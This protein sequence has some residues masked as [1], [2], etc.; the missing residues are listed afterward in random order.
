M[1]QQPVK[2]VFFDLGETLLTFGR[3]RLGRLFRRSAR[4][5]YDYL[6]Q[7]G[8]PVGP[9]GLYALRNLAAIRFCHIGATLTGRDFDALQL[10]KRVN[11][12]I[13]VEL[14]D[15]QWD[16]LIWK[17]YQPLAQKAWIEPDIAA[18]L[19]R[20]RQMHLKL[21]ILSNTFINRCCLERHLEQIGIRRYF[22]VCLFSYEFPK[23]KPHPSIF[24][25]AADR[26]GC[27]LTNIAYVGDRLDN[28]IKP[29]LKL[30]MHAVMKNAYTN[31]YAKP[32]KNAHRIDTLAELPALIEQI[33]HES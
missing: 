4:L 7:L 1:A 21:G 23:R 28:D 5:T 9:L 22:D 11:G 6:V 24:I 10:L 26:L 8:Q 32:A 15:Q 18:T 3:L 31:K 14:T 2:A 19:D 25:K 13:G 16:E 12:K 30:Q 33:N 27:R 29:A 17:W 20:L